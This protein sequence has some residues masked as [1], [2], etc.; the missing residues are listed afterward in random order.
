[1]IYETSA[2]LPARPALADGAMKADPLLDWPELATLGRWIVK[3]PRSLVSSAEPTGGVAGWLDRA[4]HWRR[5]PVFGGIHESCTIYRR[6][7]FEGAALPRYVARFAQWDSGKD[8]EAC[9]AG[10][11]RQL[12]V[13]VRHCLF[14]QASMASIGSQAQR[15]AA[16]IAATF[17]EE[18]ITRSQPNLVYDWDFPNVFVSQSLHWSSTSRTELLEQLEL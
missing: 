1:M 18:P 2:I 11:G 7:E 4:M 16:A 10:C 12:S 15:L 17:R 3:G 13:T 9:K 6:F 8:R 14:S 5:Q